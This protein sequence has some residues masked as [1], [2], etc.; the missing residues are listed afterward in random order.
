MRRS[1][2]SKP[3]VLSS[4]NHSGQTKLGLSINP[5]RATVSVNGQ[6]IHLT[7]KEFQAL[8]YLHSR[9][10][11][12]CTKDELAQHVWPEYE[13][14]VD[15]YNI[16]QLVSRLRRKLEPDPQRPRFLLTVRGLGYRLETPRV[17]E[18]ITIHRAR[19]PSRSI[20]LSTFVLII[21]AA[22]IA[23]ALVLPSGRD[24]RQPGEPIGGT[25]RQGPWLL[26]YG[27]AFDNP[28]TSLFPRGPGSTP[29]GL[30][31]SRSVEGQEYLVRIMKVSDRSSGL[32]ALAPP[33]SFET[34]AFEAEA[35]SN[36]SIQYGLTLFWNSADSLQ[37]R[38]NP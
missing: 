18:R 27:D 29:A 11:A 6:P 19:L 22:G 7:V 1:H 26:K 9:D 4:A 2:L 30:I 17:S 32:S 35:Q 13:G 12:L 38:L 10:G 3:D 37:I 23:L 21:A 36:G 24:G 28:E 14:A 25:T 5:A 20:L 16:E 31:F 34:F 15:D 8:S 33:V